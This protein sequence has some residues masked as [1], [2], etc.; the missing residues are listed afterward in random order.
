M[1]PWF[2]IPDYLRDSKYIHLNVT[3]LYKHLIILRK[4]HIVIE[5]RKK[6]DKMPDPKN[7][8][9]QQP[10]GD[11]KITKSTNNFL[12]TDMLWHILIENR[13]MCLRNLKWDR[14]NE[15]IRTQLNK[16]RAKA[17]WDVT[18]LRIKG[19][20]SS[21]ST[22][23]IHDEVRDSDDAELSFNILLKE[24]NQDSVSSRLSSGHSE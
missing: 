12:R 1:I 22:G 20:W 3:L 13:D 6:T 2:S 15:G 4:L 18:L 23:I 19:K 5:R 10:P 9:Q 16:R 14:A 17:I 8:T 21:S 24:L 7:W 11:K